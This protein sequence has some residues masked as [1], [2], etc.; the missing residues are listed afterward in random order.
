MAKTLSTNFSAAGTNFPLATV[1][2]DPLTKEDVFTL[3]QALEQHTHDA[4]RGLAV[5]RI[6][7]ANA[8]ASAGQVQI[9]GDAL[10]WWANTAGA[11]RVLSAPEC[12]LGCPD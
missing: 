1:G 3:Q 4:T 11:V 2:T 12:R 9:S 10:S 6:N 5:R 8:P 7:T